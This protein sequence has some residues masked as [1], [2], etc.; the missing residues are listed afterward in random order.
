MRRVSRTWSKSSSINSRSSDPCFA[1]IYTSPREALMSSVRLL[2]CDFASPSTSAEKDASLMA[3]DC[4]PATRPAIVFESS[5]RRSSI[6]GTV[7]ANWSLSQEGGISCQL[8]VSRRMGRNI[9]VV[10]CTTFRIHTHN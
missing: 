4:L 2:S 8:T 10:S 3:L 5:C 9:L 1:L 7:N 6:D